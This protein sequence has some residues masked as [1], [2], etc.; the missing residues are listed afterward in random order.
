M[1]IKEKAFLGLLTWKT[2][3]SVL[4]R[5]LRNKKINRR[6]KLGPVNRRKVTVAAAQ[7]ELK[8]MPDAR[9]YL[10]EMAAV[11]ARAAEAN[12]RLLVFPENNSFSLLGLVPGIEEMAANINDTNEEAPAVT[13][14]DLFR[15][16]GPVFNRVA[17]TAFSELART[18]GLFIMAG[19]F[20]TPVKNRV[21]NRALLFGPDGAL[22]GTQDKVHLMPQEHDWGLSPG[23]SFTVF[24]TELGNM[25]APVC[26]DATYFETFRILAGKGAEI[27]A[28]PIA[29][30][31]PYNQW[32]ALR[33]IW[34]RVQESLV[35]GVKSALVGKLFGFE[36]TGKAGIFAPLPLTPLQDGVLAEATAPDRAGFVSADLDLEALHE[37]RRTHPYLGDTN[38]ALAAKYFPS[39]YETIGR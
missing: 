2:R 3:P 18:Y 12:A 17:H 7:L 36:L 16:L 13:V 5:H 4:V 6:G 35:Y 15:F 23:D 10:D 29:N 39:V 25:A 11:A 31:E 28:V 9:D 19:S 26:M 21:V 8:L 34:P 33:G 37:L 30:A 22:L 32:L 1:T 24:P 20:P 27:V 38:P 14:A